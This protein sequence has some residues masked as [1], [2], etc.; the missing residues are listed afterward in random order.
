MDW[1]RYAPDQVETW[2]DAIVRS[3]W[4]HG[5]ERV[6][7][8]HGAADVPA[9]GTPGY[10][11]AVSGRGSIKEILRQRL[12]RGRWSRWAKGRREGEHDVSEGEMTI[13]LRENPA[14]DRSARWP[15]IPPPAY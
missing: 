12:Y 1:H 14:P 8:V 6:A 13:A 5:F 11:G 4:E 15:V 9:R 10:P 7:F 2:A 3:A